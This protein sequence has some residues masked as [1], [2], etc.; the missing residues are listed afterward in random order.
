MR[1]IRFRV[2]DQ[3]NK[4]MLIDVQNGFGEYD[5]RDFLECVGFEVMQYTGVEDI[6]G[7][8]IFEGDFVRFYD[9]YNDPDNE[10]PLYGI[11]GFSDAAFVIK[12]EYDS[13]YAWSNHNIEVIGNKFSIMQVLEESGG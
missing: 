8:H 5:F 6:N 10:K 7:K 11:V 12:T 13:Y 3:E 2:W 9:A 4:K 1:T